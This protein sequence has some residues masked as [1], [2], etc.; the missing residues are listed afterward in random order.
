MALRHVFDHL[1]DWVDRFVRLSRPAS[2]AMRLAAEKHC[3][4]TMAYD[5]RVGLDRA[6]FGAHSLR[7]G[8]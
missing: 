5:H 8:P 1:A 6:A 4:I 3:D 7:V 2:F